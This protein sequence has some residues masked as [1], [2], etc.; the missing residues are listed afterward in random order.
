[1]NHQTPTPARRTNQ[2]ERKETMN[3]TRLQASGVNMAVSTGLR[4][5]AY[6]DAG[7]LCGRPATVLDKK[8]GGMVCHVHEPKPPRYQVT[9][10]YLAKAEEILREASEHARKEAAAGEQMNAVKIVSLSLAA[11]R[12]RVELEGGA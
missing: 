12:I 4:C 1:M 10:S 3:S 7:Y 8:R 6:T 5:I 11:R 2:S 9:R